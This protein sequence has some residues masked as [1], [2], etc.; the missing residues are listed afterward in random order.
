[1]FA[2]T[3]AVTNA[4]NVSNFMGVPI[5]PGYLKAQDWSNP[6]LGNRLRDAL[7]PKV[8]RVEVKCL[9]VSQGSEDI[10]T[11]ISPLAYSRSVG[12]E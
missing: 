2:T 5:S 1:M 9:N 11:G 6:S 12:G 8:I 3:T 10:N 4:N 7:I